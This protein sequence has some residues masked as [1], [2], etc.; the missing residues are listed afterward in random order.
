M[1]FVYYS[2]TWCNPCK[3][4][5]PWVKQVAEEV[6]ADVEIVD[7]SDGVEGILSVPTLD[8][9]AG[10]ETLKRIVRWSGKKA[11]MREIE[12]LL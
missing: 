12:E 4:I 5:W 7:I 3:R 1:K 6:G 8:I 9:I 11:L 2:A 10:G